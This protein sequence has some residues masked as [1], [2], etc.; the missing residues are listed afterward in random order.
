MAKTCWSASSLWP[1]ARTCRRFQRDTILEAL[2]MRA[3]AWGLCVADAL[4]SDE[5]A[6]IRQL[7]RVELLRAAERRP[8]AAGDVHS[9]LIDAAGRVLSCGREWDPYEVD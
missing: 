7:R 9:L 5:P 2:V 3:R 1:I 6:L 8:L 4:V